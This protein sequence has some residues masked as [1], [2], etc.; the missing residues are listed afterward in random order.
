MSS[1]IKKR[2]RQDNKKRFQLFQK[3]HKELIETCGLRTSSKREQSITFHDLVDHPETFSWIDIKKDSL[4]I[5]FL[6]IEKVQ[7]EKEEHEMESRYIAEGYIL[8]EFR[9]Q[10][11]MEKEVLH[12]LKLHPKTYK[13]YILNKNL[14]AQEFWMKTFH[15]AGY[16]EAFEEREITDI[17][18]LYTYRKK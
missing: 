17:D 11:L 1:L 14:V 7:T 4:W 8:P 13:L 15:K 2:I 5:G 18:T 3:Y 16:C 9:R 6:V 12:Y 10:H